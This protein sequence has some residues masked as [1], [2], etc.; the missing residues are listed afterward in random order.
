[1]LQRLKFVYALSLTITFVLS[2]SWPAQ[3]SYRT[4]LHP[5]V[6]VSQ[7]Y[8][9]NVDQVDDDLKESEWIT[10]ISPSLA[11]DV[12]GKTKGFNLSY[13]PGFTFYADRDENDTVRQSA[14][15]NAW[16]QPA[17]HLD[18]RWNNAFTRTEEPYEVEPLPL[19]LEDLPRLE[20]ED[21][22]FR[23][24]RAPRS[25]YTSR[26]NL[27]YQFGP[28]DKANLGYRFRSVWDESPTAEDSIE[29]SPFLNISYWLSPQWGTEYSAEY[30][31]GEFSGDTD[32]DDTDSFDEYTASVRLIRKFSKF[33]DG[34]MQYKHTIFNNHGESEDY[35]IFDPSVGMSWRFAQDGNL[36]LS[37]GY[38]IKDNEDSDTDS[39]VS[40][41]ADIS[42][43]F[44]ISRRTSF[45]ITGGSGYEQSY[46]G[47]ENLG[48]T[49]FFQGRGR[50]THQFT[51]R[52]GSDLS[53][54]YRRNEFLDQ[55]PERED[56]IYDFQ[57]GLSWQVLRRISLRLSN[58]YRIV[59][60]NLERDEYK[61]N[62]IVLSI[63]YTPKP[64]LF[65]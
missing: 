55:T 33:V 17:K 52:L 29:H 50:L 36:S 28:K 65:K 23:R 59:D 46:F 9:D 7:E 2:V 30:T 19:D 60:S 44:D 32:T 24:D 14:S 35:Q 3:A 56:N 22:T 11:L 27:G 51:K 1:M 25:S 21:F 45:R 49:V 54:S 42:K 43:G 16:A 18:L 26:I 61:E 37:L 15:L 41:S 48:F 40:I 20:P 5:S 63:T 31:R 12:V 53:A 8:T 57:V 4:T 34:Y 62:R 47:A 58:T 6:S 38:Y 39:D 64:F 13:T 10:V